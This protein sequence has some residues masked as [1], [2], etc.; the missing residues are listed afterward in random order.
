MLAYPAS[1]PMP[2]G[3]GYGFEPVSPLVRSKLQSGRTRQRRRFTSVPTISSVSWLLDD[4]EAQ[5]FEAWFE[6]VLVSGSLWFECPLKT[7]LGLDDYRARFADIY[8]GPELVDGYWRFTASL[9]LFKRPILDSDWVIVAPDYILMSDIFDRAM[10]Q[11]WP[12]P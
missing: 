6:H 4:R 11:E 8:S 12:V 3:D 5:F 9:E 10:N 1:L 7:P 2:V